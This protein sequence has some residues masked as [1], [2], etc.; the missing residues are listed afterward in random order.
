[1]EV[2]DWGGSNF[3]EEPLLGQCKEQQE[4]NHIDV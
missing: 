4:N 1:M 2:V 3:F